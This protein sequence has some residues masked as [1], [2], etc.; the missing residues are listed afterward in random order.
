MQRGEAAEPVQAERALPRSREAEAAWFV[1]HTKSR[2]EK[3]VAADLQAMGIAHYLPLVAYRRRYE[4]R[5]ATV[6][7]PLFAG[8]VFLHGTLD[9]AYEIDRT[10][11]IVQVIR[12]PNQA[13]VEWELA[14][15]H[16]AL[17]QQAVL[18]PYPYLQKGVRVEVRSGP[19]RGLQGLIEDRTQRDRLILQVEM[20]GRAMS[21]EIDGALDRKSVV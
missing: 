3:K 6:D 14:N 4:K 7:L 8:Y 13:Q 18:D 20:L 9:N 11:R 15:I 12:V 2:Q 17:S 16:L 19:M 1:L 21:M 5:V 10:R